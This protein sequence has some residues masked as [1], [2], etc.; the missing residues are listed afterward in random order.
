M[1]G[2]GGVG[3]TVFFFSIFSRVNRGEGKTNLETLTV[4]H[5]TDVGLDPCGCHRTGEK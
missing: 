1:C 4:M 2:G 3:Q 5:M